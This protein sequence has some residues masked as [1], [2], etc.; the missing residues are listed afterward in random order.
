MEDH[1]N[2]AKATLLLFD[3]DLRIMNYGRTN[4]ITDDP[5]E[6]G[7]LLASAH[8]CGSGK[9]KSAYEKHGVKWNSKVPTETQIYL[10]K[11]DAVWEWLHV[12]P[13]AVR[14]ITIHGKEIL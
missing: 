4:H 5:R 11:F 2:A 7:R 10:K 12:H 14:S 6:I 3:A 8:N 1:E 13:Q 9:T